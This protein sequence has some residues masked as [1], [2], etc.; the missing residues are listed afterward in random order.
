VCCKPR[1]ALRRVRRFEALP[2]AFIEPSLRSTTLE[3]VHRDGQGSESRRRISQG[4][5]GQK[6]SSQLSEKQSAALEAWLNELFRAKITEGAI[7]RRIHNGKITEPLR[8][9]AVRSIVQNRAK[10]VDRW[11]H[12]WGS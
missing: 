2:G 3:N 9:R 8:D 6:T 7:F 10:L 11:I 5:G 1:A 4:R 12:R